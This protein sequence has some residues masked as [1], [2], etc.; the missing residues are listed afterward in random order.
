MPAKFSPK[1]CCREAAF[2]K[3]PEKAEK[4]PK[5]GN[6]H[7]LTGVACLEIGFLEPRPRAGRGTKLRPKASNKPGIWRCNGL[8]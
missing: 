6:M 1:R 4:T 8:P 7:A 2:G 3:L 5:V